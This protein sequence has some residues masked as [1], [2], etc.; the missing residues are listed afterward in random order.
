M[1]MCTRMLFGDR[2]LKRLGLFDFSSLI[3]LALVNPW[4]PD[5]PSLAS[6]WM[7]GVES[8]SETVK[9]TSLQLEASVCN[10]VLFNVLRLQPRLEN[11]ELRI[12]GYDGVL[13]LLSAFT[14]DHGLTGL[15]DDSMG[16]DSSSKTTVRADGT[17]DTTLPMCPQLQTLNLKLE[18]IDFEEKR[19]I[20]LPLCKIILGSRRSKGRPLRSFKVSWR[21]GEREE[22]LVP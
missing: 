4:F 5:L 3:K 22:Q 7:E 19:G 15:E 2:T 17:A 8:I 20:L 6:R 13:A 14:I 9:V 12:W 21:F 11:L 18:N 1:P 16:D 10:F